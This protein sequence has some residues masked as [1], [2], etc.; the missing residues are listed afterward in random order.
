MILHKL[1]RWYVLKTHVPTSTLGEYVSSH[2]LFKYDYVNAEFV[3]AFEID[4]IWKVGIW[5]KKV[6][7]LVQY[8]LSRSASLS[9]RLYIIS[10]IWTESFV[11][12]MMQSLNAKLCNCNIRFDS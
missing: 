1:I 7:W 6:Y 11:I 9:V 5:M 4:S 12:S 3:R 10:N 2:V 8:N